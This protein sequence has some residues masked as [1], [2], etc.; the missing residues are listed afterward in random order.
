MAT[1]TINLAGVGEVVITKR[2]KSK[3]M[4]L[5]IT[6]TGTVR[7]TVPFWLSYGAAEQF[8]SKRVDWIVEHKSKH[9][10]SVIRPGDRIGK[11]H[12][13]EFVQDPAATSSSAR[14]YDNL[15]KVK[16]PKLYTDK[17]VQQKA[18]KASEKAL[19]AEAE[20]LLPQRLEY[21]SKQ[22]NLAY[23]SVKI[24]KLT[25]RWGSCSAHGDITLSY[26]LMQLPWDLID[27]VLVHEL[28]HTK[29][30]HHGPDFWDA[31]EQ[32]K[33]GARKVRKLLNANLPRIKPEPI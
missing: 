2:R 4:R 30:M 5:S 10:E 32:L 31:M 14:V 29:H 28:V 3:S 21:F 13:I 18:V 24:K 15:I 11:S 16:S 7:V 25:S 19:K 17:L 9:P 12:R 22:H 27:Y 6:P 26:F 8:V 23:K 20:V 33:P 1:K